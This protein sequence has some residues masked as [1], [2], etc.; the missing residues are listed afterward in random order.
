MRIEDINAALGLTLDKANNKIYK[1]NDE[2]KTAISAYQK[3]LD[4][5]IHIKNGDYAPENY[6]KAKYPSR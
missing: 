2:S 4:K 1:T 3:F 5:V 6:L